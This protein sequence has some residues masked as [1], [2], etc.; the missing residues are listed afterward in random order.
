MRAGGHDLDEAGLQFA[1]LVQRGASGNPFFVVEVLRH[2]AETGAL[3]ES[4]GRWTSDLSPEE[5][6][7]PEGIRDV[8][9][10]RLVGLGADVERV[11]RLAAVIGY[12]FRLDLLSDVAGADADVVLDA[13]DAAVAANLVIEIGV[14]RHRFAHGLV[15]E[16]LHDELSSSRRAR[17]HRKVAEA[18]EARH[19]GDIDEVITE[20]ATHWAEASAGGDSTRAIEVAERAGDLAM[21]RGAYENGAGWFERARELMDD[22]DLTVPERRRVLVKLAAAQT[23]S[24]AVA[25][26][27]VERA[28]RRGG[29]R[30]RR[31]TQTRPS[32]RWASVRER[33]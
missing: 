29:R 1:R 25:E 8:V 32:M 2:L 28:H 21:R 14:D 3:V 31:G 19:A 5:V 15:R 17:Q 16:T 10:Q 9:G 27:R 18:L 23:Y 20:L 26:G 11:L 12:E 22:G 33:V 13:L 6:G 24:G 30:S 7:I 4:D